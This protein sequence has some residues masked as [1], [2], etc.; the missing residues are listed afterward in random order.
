MATVTAYIADSR[1]TD[2]TPCITASGYNIC[3]GNIPIAACPRRIRFG[4][5]ISVLGRIYICH[6]RLHP[7]YDERI[8][9]LMKSYDEAIN[10]G[11]QK[12]EVTIY[13]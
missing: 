12:L 8:D 1:F 4:V 9:I 5:P 10:F 3:T 7:R 11:K 2:D 6:D 13:E